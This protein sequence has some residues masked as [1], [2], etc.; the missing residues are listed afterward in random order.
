LP[1][2]LTGPSWSNCVEDQV[3]VP[4]PQALQARRSD[5]RI[6]LP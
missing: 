6:E 1:P 2:E 4:W 3:L 5:S